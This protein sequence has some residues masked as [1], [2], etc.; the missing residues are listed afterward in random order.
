MVQPPNPIVPC[1][2][3]LWIIGYGYD[4]ISR[5]IFGTNKER[6]RIYKWRKYHNWPDHQDSFKAYYTAYR[7]THP[8]IIKRLDPIEK[9][10]RQQTRFSKKTKQQLRIY[11]CTQINQSIRHGLYPKSTPKLVGCSI[12]HL[13][14]HLE[15][16]FQAEMN[17]SNYGSCWEIDH[18]KPVHSFNIHDPTERL[19]CYHFTNLQP[20]T[21]HQNRVKH[22]KIHPLLKTGYEATRIQ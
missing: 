9:D 22:T 15:S 16:L 17:W 5:L 2:R 21:K 13:K 11:L 1:A 6:Q 20:L 7:R 14:A 10:L 18:I 12:P 19:T 4:R 3:C 8:P